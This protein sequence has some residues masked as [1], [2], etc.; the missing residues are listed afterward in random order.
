[1]NEGEVEIRAADFSVAEEY[2]AL[3]ARA[4]D[5]GACVVFTGRV[6]GEG[7]IGALSALDLEHYPGMTER[8]IAAV[9]GEARAR[10]PV[11]ALRAVHRVGRIGVGEQIVFVGVAAAHRGAAFKA[12]EFLM[13]YLK[14]RAPIWKK[15]IGPAG[16][17]WVESRAADAAAAARWTIDDEER[18]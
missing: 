8:S 11:Q 14:T 17:H 4:P 9:I 7:E 12:A 3:C 10:W 15:E 1:M 5:S 18:S 13:D 16:T 2:A 6:R